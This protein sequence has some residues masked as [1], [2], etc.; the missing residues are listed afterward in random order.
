MPNASKF[1]SWVNDEVLPMIRKT[2]GGLT[3]EWAIHRARLWNGFSLKPFNDVN[4]FIYGK[5]ITSFT[6]K[7]S[8]HLNIS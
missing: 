5:I 7:P 1:E 4:Q 6:S 8:D 3:E 2:G